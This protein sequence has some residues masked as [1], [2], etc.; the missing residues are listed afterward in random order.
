MSEELDTLFPLPTVAVN[1]ENGWIGASPCYVKDLAALR[2]KCCAAIFE[3]Q[4]AVQLNI[5]GEMTSTMQRIDA[6]LSYTARLAGVC[7]DA[8]AVGHQQMHRRATPLEFEWC[9]PAEND[10]QRF[11]PVCCTRSTLPA[12]EYLC[13]LSVACIML[14]GAANQHRHQGNNS[15]AITL[16]SRCISVV[17]HQVARA[18]GHALNAA[19]WHK[20][21]RETLPIQLL[22]TWL[23]LLAAKAAH[24][25]QLCAIMYTVHSGNNADTCA[26]TRE[27]FFSIRAVS[28]CHRRLLCLEPFLRECQQAT[29]ADLYAD[30]VRE[31]NRLQIQCFLQEIESARLTGNATVAAAM[32]ESCNKS[33]QVV[34]TDN[35]TEEVELRDSV[36]QQIQNYEATVMKSTTAAMPS[37]DTHY[38]LDEY[39]QGLPRMHW[40]MVKC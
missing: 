16:Y 22:P 35:D 31:V 3:Q 11:L 9:F 6:I 5:S 23:S 14:M 25:A 17:Q 7:N 2:R 19:Q 40:S 4:Q 27:A 34:W 37:E 28:R 30:T 1:W 32:L 38:L 8:A 33:V 15:E 20:L 26:L 24:S 29:I 18:V 21:R 10:P 36:I 39:M 12:F 13:M